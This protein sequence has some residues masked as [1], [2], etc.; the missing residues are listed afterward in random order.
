MSEPVTVSHIM[1]LIGGAIFGA[2]L[3][4]GMKI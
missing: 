1:A 3:A 2:L 4:L